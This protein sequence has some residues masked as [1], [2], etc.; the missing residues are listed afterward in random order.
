VRL[1]GDDQVEIADIEHLIALHHR[2]IGGEVDAVGDVAGSVGVDVDARLAR[3][4]FLEH[5]VGLLAQL[6][7]VAQERGCAW[8]SAPVTGAS[9][10]DTA[11]RVLPVP[12]ARTIER[13]AVAE[14][15]ALADALDGLDLIHPARDFRFRIEANQAL[16]FSW[17]WKIRY[18]RLSFE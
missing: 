11:T 7:T 13:L 14:A 18:C 12:V 16:S 1:V 9:H 5:V 17:R 2:R 8:P 3:Q 4:K 10:S 6:A 15:E